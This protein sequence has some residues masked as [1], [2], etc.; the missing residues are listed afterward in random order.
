MSVVLVRAAA[1]EIM[2][3]L[4]NAAAWAVDPADR[5]AA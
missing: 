4:K 3:E 5:R 1:G 2:D